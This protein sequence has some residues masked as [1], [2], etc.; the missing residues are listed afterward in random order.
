M[1]E[2]DLISHIQIDKLQVS[3][4]SDPKLSKGERPEPTEEPGVYKKLRKNKTQSG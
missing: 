2:N 1:R 4:T 3:D